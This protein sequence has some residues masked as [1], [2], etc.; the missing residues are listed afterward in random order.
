[1]LADGLRGDE[2]LELGDELRVTSEREI[3]LDPLLERDG[4]Q[5]LEPRD[6]GLGERLVEEV[7]ERRPA[8]ERECLT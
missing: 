4:A 2:C 3:R 6:L 5:L 8:P 1:M 7:R